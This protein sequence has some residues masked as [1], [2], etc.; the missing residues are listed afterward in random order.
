MKG[1]RPPRRRLP[2]RLAGSAVGA[3]PDT[4][5]A[6]ATFEEATPPKGF[7]LPKP[8]G[9]RPSAGGNAANLHIFFR[10]RFAEVPSLNEPCPT[11]SYWRGEGATGVAMETKPKEQATHSFMSPV[12]AGPASIWSCLAGKL[13]FWGTFLTQRAPD[14]RHAKTVDSEWSQNGLGSPGPEIGRYKKRAEK[15]PVLSSQGSGSPGRHLTR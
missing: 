6:H 2:A 3:F 7:G 11:L 13:W 5:S 1:L 9:K 15:R 12:A 14:L 10:F 4:D 8:S